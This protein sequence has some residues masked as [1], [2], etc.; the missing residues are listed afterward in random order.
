MYC[1]YFSIGKCL[2]HQQIT[3]RWDYDGK[4]NYAQLKV[5]L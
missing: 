4:Y 5:W 1:S 3:S 2:T